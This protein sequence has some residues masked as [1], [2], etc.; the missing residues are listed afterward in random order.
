MGFNTAGNSMR[1]LPQGTAL[2]GT[3]LMVVL[4][5]GCST[6]AYPKFNE[7]TK[8]VTY[9]EPDENGD[10]YILSEQYT[11]LKLKTLVVAAPWKGDA[12]TDLRIEYIAFDDWSITF[13]GTTDLY[14]GELDLAEI[15][16]AAEKGLVAG[17][18]EPLGL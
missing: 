1:F 11:K 12:V 7:K 5:A 17:A 2:V 15:V 18:L 4:L 6:F 3:L 16:E 13:G 9:S 8:L 10:Q 14:G